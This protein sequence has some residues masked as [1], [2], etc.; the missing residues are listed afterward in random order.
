MRKTFF[1]SSR[2]RFVDEEAVIGKLKEIAMNLAR[3]DR[4]IEA[5][6]LFG[7]YAKRGAAGL[8]SDADILVVLKED[9]R[10]PIDRLDE[11]M[12][13]FLD[14]PVPVDVLVYTKAELG[15]A[16]KE[17]NRFL[18]RAVEGIRLAGQ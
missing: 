17:G 12:P 16:L 10:R 15:K 1:P 13:A 7:S 8:R 14:A 3:A 5:I 9:S 18:A 2:P 6:Y 4:N 11:F